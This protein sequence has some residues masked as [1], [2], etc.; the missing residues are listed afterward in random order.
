MLYS[1]YCV[2]RVTDGNRTYLNCVIMG[3]IGAVERR[4]IDYFLWQLMLFH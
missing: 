1:V 3:L 2:Y 4:A